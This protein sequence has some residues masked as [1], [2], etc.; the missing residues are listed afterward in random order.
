MIEP[1]YDA[2]KEKPKV[3]TDVLVALSAG[4][5][6]DGQV[7][8]LRMVG[9]LESDGSWTVLLPGVTLSNAPVEAWRLLPEFFPA[10]FFPA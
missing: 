3:K 4:D 2:K 6:R 8:L 1:W 7:R 5:P 9:W 10:E